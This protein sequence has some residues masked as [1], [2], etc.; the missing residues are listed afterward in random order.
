MKVIKTSRRFR[1]LSLQLTFCQGCHVMTTV[2]MFNFL[3]DQSSPSLTMMGIQHQ[4]GRD[5]IAKIY[6]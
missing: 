5:L 6:K 3:V 2:M 4:K 1:G